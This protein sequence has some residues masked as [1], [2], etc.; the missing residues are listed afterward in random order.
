MNASEPH[1]DF[2]LMRL[3]AAAQE[4]AITAEQLA[5]L[6]ERLKTDPEARK[7]YLR[8]TQLHALLE[9][10]PPEVEV[11]GSVAPSELRL[12]MKAAFAWLVGAMLLAVT[13]TS[14]L[15]L[16]V[17]PEAAEQP[18]ATLLLDDDCR[19]QGTAFAEGQRIYHERIRLA[20]GTAVLRF[21]GGAELVLQGPGDL[22]LLSPGSA[23][24][25]SGKTVIRAVN[26][27]D[28]FTLIT[29]NQK[30]VDLGTEF[31]VRVDSSGATELFV[32]E[33]EVEVGQAVI[34]AGKGLRF[35]KA[36]NARPQELAFHGTRFEDLIREIEPKPREDLMT[37]YAG[38][39]YAPG[40]L[41][42]SES[43]RGKGWAGPWRKRNADERRQ[44][45]H[46]KTPDYLRIVHGEL[47]VTWPV[48]GGRLGM[49][50]FPEG[51]SIYVRDLAKPITMQE[52]RV[53]YFSLMVLEPLPSDANPSDWEAMR[54]TFRASDDYFGESLS[55]GYGNRFQPKIQLGRGI[56]FTSPL[57][58]PD[59]QTTLW[60]GKIVSR[61]KGE[62]EIR[63]RVYGEADP[64]DYAEPSAWHVVT[65]DADLSARFDRVLLT[66]NGQE[67]RIVDELRIGPTWRS[68]VPFKSH[69]EK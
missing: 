69:P 31:S 19:W 48:P 57:L 55:F 2:E 35:E 23:R 9:Q 26:G 65:R 13:L 50:E 45:D 59:A 16:M 60:V 12:P 27:A 62:D 66:C 22:E 51:G 7:Q 56:S 34:P 46:E 14:M 67:P 11:A 17:R 21:E 30:V 10:F 68:V 63:F 53:W 5:A 37:A 18:I 29:P 38:F 25:R 15:Y 28:G 40:N 8:F 4:D 3:F 33:G 39:H 58:T 1:S 42:L 43:T 24:L 61:R 20:Q 47:N 49:L 36:N 41:P 54:L 32:H 6:E 52:D 44:P 64:L